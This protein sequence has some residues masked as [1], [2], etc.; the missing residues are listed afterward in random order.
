LIRFLVR[1]VS[2]SSAADWV[3]INNL[4]LSGYTNSTDIV[5]GGGRL[6][7]LTG[8]GSNLV[9]ASGNKKATLIRSSYK[10]NIAGI[11]HIC[12]IKN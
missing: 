5:A 9:I 10:A 8:N 4:A 3:K 11:N 12:H 2:G 7:F 6:V 1:F